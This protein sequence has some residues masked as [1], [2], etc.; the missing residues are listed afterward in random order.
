MSSTL[1][2]EGKM[3]SFEVEELKIRL[4]EREIEVGNRCAMVCFASL[5]NLLLEDHAVCLSVL[6]P[7]RDYRHVR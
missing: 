1:I 7:P 4:R 2:V 3:M 5:C 6:L